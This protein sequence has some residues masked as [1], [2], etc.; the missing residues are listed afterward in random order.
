M[1]QVDPLACAMLGPGSTDGVPTSAEALS[2]VFLGLVSYDSCAVSSTLSSLNISN[3]SLPVDATR[4]RSL[5]SMLPD[6]AERYLREP[7]RMVPDAMHGAQELLLAPEPYFDPVPTHRRRTYVDLVRLLARPGTVRFTLEPEE[8]V[9]LFAV[10]KDNG[11]KQRLIIV[12]ARRSNLRLRPCPNV[13]LLSSEGFSKLEVD[14]DATPKAWFGITDIKDCFHNMRIPDWFSDYFSLLHVAAWE[15][16]IE[17][18]T[19]VQNGRRVF[20]GRDTSVTPA[21]QSYRWGARGC[22]I[23]LRASPM[24]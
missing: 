20:L 4:A 23:L 3:L 22:C 11:Q 1:A 7:E 24:P 9:G 18:S 12:D 19:L 21:W 15:A 10:R 5:L 2:K 16:E 14:R 17:G 8:R 13:A 6:C